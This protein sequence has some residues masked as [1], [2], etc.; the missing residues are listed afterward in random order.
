M[1]LQDVQ[2]GEFGGFAKPYVTL[3]PSPGAEALRQRGLVLETGAEGLAVYFLGDPLRW[4]YPVPKKV[5]VL[6]DNAWGSVISNG[7]FSLEDT[8]AYEKH[9]LNIA[10]TSRQ[11]ENCFAESATH[12]YVDEVKLF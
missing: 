2:F 1:L 7:R 10:F 3:T 5:F 4:Q 11:L 9:I 6:Q 8:W 12:R